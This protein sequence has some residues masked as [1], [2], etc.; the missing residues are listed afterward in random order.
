MSNSSQILTPDITIDITNDVC[1]MTFVK[2]RLKLE[3]MTP[4]QILEV[5]LKDGEPLKNVPRSVTEMGDVVLDLTKM[6]NDTGT[7]R[8][9]IRK[10]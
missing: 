7:Y 6:A 9:T 1:P 8:L 3:K 2:T 10:N 5:I 4:G